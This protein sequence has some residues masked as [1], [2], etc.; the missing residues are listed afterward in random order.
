MVVD[1]CESGRVDAWRRPLTTV[2]LV[3]LWGLAVLQPPAYST[4]AQAGSGTVDTNLLVGSNGGTITLADVNGTNQ[5]D[6]T[7]D[8]PA[9][10][11]ISGPDL[12]P[13]GTQVAFVAHNADA[14]GQ[15]YVMDI[16][17]SGL[18]P[19]VVGQDVHGPKWAPD[20]AQLTYSTVAASSA[21]TIWTVNT[22]GSSDQV[23]A[24][25]EDPSWTPD[26]V[27]I[28]FDSGGNIFM[29]P[30]IGGE[31]AQLTF[32]STP[33]DLPAL[34]ADFTNPVWSPSGGYAAFVIPE[35]TTSSRIE[36]V[37]TTNWA[38]PVAGFVTG[39]GPTV[40]WSPDGSRLLV[41]L[42]QGGGIYNLSGQLQAPNPV[43]PDASW[44]RPS[45]PQ[46][47]QGGY[48]VASS[49][50]GVFSFGQ[51]GFFGSHGGSPLNEPVVGISAS[52]DNQGYWLVASDGGI[53]SYGDARFRGSMGGQRLNQ[54]VVGMAADPATGGYWLVASDGGIFSFGA[55]YLGSM[56]GIPLHEPIVGMAAMPDGLGYWL[57]AA[58]GGIF[59]FGDARY[60]GSMGGRLLNAPITA[61]AATPDGLGYWLVASDGGIFSFGDAPYAGN[62][63]GP[64]PTMAVGLVA[65]SAGPGYVIADSNG[66]VV[67]SGAAQFCGAVG[68][69]GNA[70][71]IAATS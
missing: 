61:M 31:V 47:C 6:I 43:G 29:V 68:P 17:G 1:A 5:R 27:E 9:G 14:A 23:L 50:G 49:D 54:P 42:A 58:D 71:V 59:S 11:Q 62:G 30:D 57:V 51:S 32:N 20:G 33:D 38:T 60:F 36:V 53:F 4:T 28:V 19:L 52:S 13:D 41:G 65:S 15:L 24:G 18:T 7:P 10:T 2:A 34:G 21:S 55:P 40:S 69:Y 37:S 16:D 8:L 25:G 66:A 12:A 22:N 45:N 3:A 44:I 63:T 46:D 56:G 26:G 70:P 35:S 48:R 64:L 67:A 39:A